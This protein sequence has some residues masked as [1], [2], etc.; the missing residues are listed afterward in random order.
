M[1]YKLALSTILSESFCFSMKI[2]FL[3]TLNTKEAERKKLKSL[4]LVVENPQ[5]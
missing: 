1:L 2:M 3:L 5:Q 4:L